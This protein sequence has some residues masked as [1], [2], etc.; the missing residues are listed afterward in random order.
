MIAIPFFCQPAL[1]PFCVRHG[2]IHSACRN[3]P[4]SLVAGL[5]KQRATEQNRH[6][7][8]KYP[9]GCQEGVNSSFSNIS[10]SRCKTAP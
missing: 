1:L 2:L 4:G 10:H 6:T 8:T 3:V 7:I 5:K 9:S